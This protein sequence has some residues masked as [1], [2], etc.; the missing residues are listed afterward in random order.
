MYRKAL[1]LV[2][3]NAFGS[4]LSL[5]R[6]LA[7]ARIVSPEDY[8]IAATFAISMSIVEMFSYLGLQQLM[9]VDRDADSPRFQ[10]A[11]QGFQVLRG[12]LSA[13]LLL[14]IAGPY[15][16]FLGIGH[17]TWAFQLVAVIPLM[18]GLQHFDQHRL[19]RHM[20]FRASVITT[21]VPPLLSVLS[22]LP[23]ALIFDDYRI[24]LYAIL[25]QAVAMVVVSHLV[26]ERRYGV[27][28]DTGLMRRAMV[29]G[30]PLLLNGILLFAVF[31]G[32]KL[33]VGRELGMAALAVFSMGFTL[34]LTPTLVMASSLQ[35]FFVPLL[36]RARDDARRFQT[37]GAATVE[38]GLVI[39]VALVLATA[40]VG[41]PVVH[42]LLGP[43]YDALLPILVQL[44]VLQAARVSKSGSS[45]VALA[46]ER[47]G[48]AIAGNLPRILAIPLAWVIVVR[49]GDIL[50]VIWIGILAEACG[51]FIGLWL[52][53][54]RA[55]LHTRPLMPT[56][57]L[58]I[59]FH[60]VA[61]W[62][63]TANVPQPDLFRQVHLGQWAVIALGIA[64]LASMR[65][66][67]GVALRRRARE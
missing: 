13:L 36:T 55:G 54:Q 46:K 35:T 3:G 18:N 38:A 1:I 57:A 23:L 44:A 53:R 34:T 42:L 10:A 41:G 62:D 6:N 20:N 16:R 14:L 52:S 28:F 51:F 39:G 58:C 11:S 47:T 48:N 45:F 25:V 67:I 19:K 7:V 43:K 15:A 64:A 60:A 65:A 66:L 61:L 37:L 32:E 40:L 30:W 31:N 59:A 26:A 27:V 9:V 21:A 17:V 33:I 50:S 2:S 22:L 49:T 12:M 5:V 4:A 56:V 29:F 8:G 63:A 24:M